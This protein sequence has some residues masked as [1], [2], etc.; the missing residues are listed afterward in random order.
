MDEDE[1]L[2]ALYACNHHQ[3]YVNN[4]KQKKTI[5]YFI[6]KIKKKIYKLFAFFKN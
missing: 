1:I 5:K 6:K 2:G 3:M 4:K